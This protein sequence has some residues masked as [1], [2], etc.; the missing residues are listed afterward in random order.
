[1]TNSLVFSNRNNTTYNQQQDTTSFSTSLGNGA[2]S[3]DLA[4]FPQVGNHYLTI[5]G[6]TGKGGGVPQSGDSFTVRI[7]ARAT[8]DGTAVTA[9]HDLTINLT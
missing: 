8:V 9:T 5:I 6:L 3:H 2:G 7:I 4:Q 1:M